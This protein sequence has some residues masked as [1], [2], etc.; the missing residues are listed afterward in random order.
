MLAAPHH[1]ITVAEY[2]RMIDAG[3]FA[4]DAHI[5]LI[6]GEIIDVSPMGNRHYLAVRELAEQISAALRTRRDLVISSQSPIILGPRDEPEP[7]VTIS[8]RTMTKP[9]AHQVRMVVEVGDATLDFD[10]TEK[11]PRYARAGI[12]E[13]WLVDLTNDRIDVHTQPGPA[14]Y[15]ACRTVSWD[16]TLDV[17]FTTSALDLR[18]VF[19]KSG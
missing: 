6:D 19:G 14:G 3:A 17:P 18:S 12:P 9:E 11:L 2:H 1:V 4:P 15:G 8:L 16:G 5:E 7:D 13:A 10:R